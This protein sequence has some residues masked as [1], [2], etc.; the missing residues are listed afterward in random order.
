MN[1]LYPLLAALL[2]TVIALAQAPQKMS[3]QAVVRDA[4]GHL[5]INKQIAIQIGLKVYSSEGIFLRYD[6]NERHVTTTNT[7]GLVTLEIGNGEPSFG[8]FSKID[9][10]YGEHYIVV[11][12][13]LDGGGTYSISGESKLLS[14][15]Y[16]LYAATAEKLTGAITETD[17]LF[18][19]S[20]AS[21]IT[22]TDTAK[23][24]QSNTAAGVQ[25]DSAGIATMGYVAGPKT[26]DTKLDE[27]AVDAFVAN[28]G[29]LTQEKDSSVTNEI[30][31]PTGGNSGQILSTDGSGTYSWIDAGAGGLVADTINDGT[32]TVAP[33][34]NAVFD[35]L[36]LKAPIAS[37][38]FTGTVA[39]I[40]KTMV[41]LTNVDNTSDANK[42]VGTATQTVLDLKESAN[43]KSTDGTL[44]TNSDNLFPTEKAVKTYVDAIAASA[45]VADA[46]TTA[47]GKIQLA[48]DLS[49]TATAPTVPSL[50]L[51]APLASPTFTGEPVAPTAT[52]GTNTTQVATTAFVT[53]AVLQ[54]GTA[55]GQMNYWN[56]TA[57]VVVAPGA[58][59]P[60]NQAQTLVFCNGVPTWGTC[61]AVVPTLTSTTAASSIGGSTASS[62]GVIS[63]DGGG[64]ITARGVAWGT[65]TS[66]TISGSYTADG[67]GT[68][69]FT[70][71]L[72]GLTGNTTY[73][74]RAYATNSA[75]TAYGAEV[76]FITDIVIP[77]SGDIGD[78]YQGGKVAYIL[79]SGDPGY[80]AGEVHGL[81]AATSDQSTGIIWNNDGTKA[82]RGAT[83]EVIGTGLANTNAIINKQG[84]PATSYA[85]GLARAYTGGGYTDWYLPSKEEL[86]KLYIN[87]V[88]IGGFALVSESWYWNSTE[89]NL[90]VFT[91]AWCQNF[92]NGRQDAM[93]DVTWA[94]Y[95]RA[96]RSF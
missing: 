87:R 40:D 38:T 88:A 77:F 33:S 52:S 96:V 69:S 57:W 71:S 67:T 36:A 17:P 94:V 8:T 4:G 22:A 6:Y 45:G 54:P 16:A 68:G 34:Q 26:I 55:T 75:G 35:G 28:N 61:P 72:S 83:G 91:F 78:A 25:L 50:A 74:V 73:Y 79:Q 66:P 11:G 43:N 31:L 42:P 46:S 9:W 29:Y 23:W 41:G 51:K 24:N 85:A 21:K 2:L 1:R 32:T 70:S 59:L 93:N 27:T 12:I 56:G 53:A 86:N 92:Y 20:V 37:P 90:S 14:V 13:D 84:E 49:G 76:S 64:S 18:S 80:V 5:I 65:N 30:E 15:P 89:Y 39:G 58:S 7:N 48:G 81:I 62:G 44:A 3:Y 82:T 19:S 63:D 47:A 10:T 95:V 60:G